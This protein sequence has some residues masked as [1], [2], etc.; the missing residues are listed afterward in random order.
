MKR[1][2][3]GGLLLGLV[4]GALVSAIFAVGFAAGA[5]FD[6]HEVSSVVDL[7]NPDVRNFLQTYKL[8]SQRSYY[9]IGQ[10][11]LMYAAIDGM[12]SATGDPHTIFLPAN[13]NQTANQELNGQQFSGI[14]AIVVPQGSFLRVLA[15]IPGEPAAKAGIRENDVITAIDGRPVRGL[16]SQSALS[17]IHG[18][19]GS[20]VHLTVR[21]SNRT[22]RVIAVTRGKIP[23]ITAYGRML[24]HQ[25]G[26]IQIFSFGANTAREVSLALSDLTSRHMRALVLDLRGNPGGYVDAAQSIVSRFVSHGVVAY[27]QDPNKQLVPL[28]VIPHMRLTTVRVA[29]LV[30]QN[31]A[32][33]AEITTAA[34]R[35]DDG[36]RVFGTRTYGKGSMQSV[37]SLAGGASVRIT[38]RLWLTP[39][40][41]SIGGVG[42]RPDV[43]VSWN[44][45]PA[46]QPPASAIQ[47]LLQARAG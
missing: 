46:D 47:Y 12:L 8:V 43:F 9:H 22:S 30:D 29:V 32:S 3:G 41:T 4:I 11:Q 36:A 39:H 20:V 34:L 35:F 44:T 10:H 19:A 1:A 37:Y 24:P 28:R 26:Y 21:R 16:S 40:K 14:G 17:R 38:D 5:V 18:R 25:I 27:E 31:T 13:E 15:P 42:I 23:A 33:A 2:N 7:S 6:R 45:V